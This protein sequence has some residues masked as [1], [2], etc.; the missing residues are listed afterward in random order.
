MS[1][2]LGNDYRMWIE[3]ATPGTFSE[4]MGNQNLSISRSGQTIDTGTKSDFPYSTMAA[5]LRALSI[6]ATFIPNL[7]DA[8]GYARLMT[9]VRST[10]LSTVGIQIRKGGSSGATPA[11]VVFECDMYVTQD[12][13]EL[14]QNSAVGAS[15]TFVAS[16]APDTDTLI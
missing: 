9:L 7:P 6:Q 11:D 3:S 16:A 10:T 5:G 4:I 8:N 14:N 2:K 1:K 12:D 13:N 15:V